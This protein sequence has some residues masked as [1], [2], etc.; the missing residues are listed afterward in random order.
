MSSL[1]EPSHAIGWL[2]LD[3]SRMTNGYEPPSNGMLLSEDVSDV[4]YNNSVEPINP[5]AFNMGYYNAPTGRVAQT[6]RNP[7]GE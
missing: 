2:P 6:Y 7:H 4:Y 3:A 5:P 1:M